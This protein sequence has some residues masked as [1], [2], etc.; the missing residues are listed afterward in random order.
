MKPGFSDGANGSRREVDVV[1]N[2]SKRDLRGMGLF[3]T[4]AAG[5]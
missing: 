3:G 5:G 1:I 2:V 4:L